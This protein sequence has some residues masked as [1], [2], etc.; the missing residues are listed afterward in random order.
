MWLAD[1]SASVLADLPQPPPSDLPVP[2][3]GP[4][5]FL[6]ARDGHRPLAWVDGHGTWVQW[7]SG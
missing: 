1:E 6:L 4:V 3:P 7:Q 5:P 2:P